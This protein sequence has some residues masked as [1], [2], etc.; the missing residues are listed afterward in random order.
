MGTD[1]S[2]NSC[3]IPQCNGWSNYATWCVGLWLNNEQG[4]QQTAGEIC[5]AEYEYRCQ[6]EDALKSFVE[7][8]VFGEDGQLVTGMAADLLGW[9]LE[10]ANWRELVESFQED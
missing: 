2:T 4:L 1:L 7:D 3:T 6:A 10:L 9:A 5:R 8:L